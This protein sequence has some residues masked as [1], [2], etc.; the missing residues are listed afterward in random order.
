MPSPACPSCHSEEIVK[1]GRIHNGK[2]DFKCKACGR[3]F[4]EN[5]Q[6]MPIAAVT[7]ELIDKLLLEKV[8]LAGISRVCRVSESWL[9]NLRQPQ[10]RSRSSAGECF[11]HRTYA[12]VM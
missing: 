10:V 7:K 8:P 5:P 1:K 9:Q 4:V 11:I 2:Q 12:R 3:Q 6:N